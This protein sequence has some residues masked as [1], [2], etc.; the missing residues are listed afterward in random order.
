MIDFLLVASKRLKSGEVEIY[1]KFVIKNSKDLMIRGRDFY[2]IWLEEEG[3]WSTDEQQ[4]IIKMDQILDDYAHDHID[5]YNYGY[6]ILHLWDA[7]TGM[8]DNWHKYCQ[9]QLRD[10]FNP[11]D[12]NLVFANTEVSKK[13]YSSKRL[14]YSLEAGDI[15]AYDTLMDVL[16][17]PENRLKI[18]WAIGAV[19][20]GDSKKIQKFMVLYGSA[21]TGKS[22]VLNIIQMLFKGYYTS[23]DARAVGSSSNAFALEAFKSNPLLGIQHDG[24]L[25]KISDNARLNMLV[26]HEEMSVNEKYKASFNSKFKCFLFMGTNKPVQ[27]TDA[28]SGLIRRLID[29]VPTGNKVSRKDYTKLTKRV[30]F[31]LGAIAAHCLEVYSNNKAYFDDY[32]PINMLGASNDFYNF[33]LDAYFDF[34]HDDCTTLKQAWEMYKR[35]CDDA[36]VLYPLPQRGFKEELKNYFENY[37]ERYRGPDDIRIRNYYYTFKLDKF[38]G[39][40]DY[41][42]SSISLST[43]NW[44]TLKD[45]ESVFDNVAKD[46]PA[47][48]ANKM[49]TPKIAWKNNKQILKEL[50]THKLHYVH[51]PKEHIVIDFDMVGDDGEKC[52]D[53][54]L[55][56]AALFPPTYAEVSKSGNGLHLHY[57][58]S[59]DV[60]ALSQIFDNDIEIKKSIGDSSLRR[61]LTKCNGLSIAT[62]NSGLPIKEEVQ[63]MVK[64][65]SIKSEKSLRTLIS[66]NLCKEIHSYTGPSIDFIWQILEDA[67][68]S[69]LKYDVNDMHPSVLHF[70]ASS[71]HQ[72][73]RCVNKVATMK[74][75]SEE[76]EVNLT[77]K[78]LILEGY[79]EDDSDIVFYDM[80][81]FPNLYLI[82][83][84]QIGEGNQ[85]Y[86]MINPTPKEVETFVKMKLIGFNNRGYDNHM[87][88][89]RMM[90]YSELEVYKLS[91]RII[92]RKDGNND[93]KFRE[94]YNLSYSDIYDFASAQHKMSLKK[95]EIELGIHHDEL[96]GVKWDDPVPPDMI[97]RVIEYCGFDVLASEAVFNHLRGDWE[98]R[99]I[100]AKIT[101]M[102]VNSSTNSLSTK[103]IFGNEK[104]PNGK[105]GTVF[106][107]RDLSKPISCDRYEECC[108]RYERTE[109]RVFDDLGEPIHKTYVPGDKYPDGYSIMPFFPGYAF[110]L[111]KSTYR[112][113]ELGEGGEVYAE[114]GMY[115]NVGLLDVASM[116]PTSDI[117]EWYQGPYTRK[118]MEVVMSRLAIKH[119]NFEALKNLLGGVLYEL[120]LNASDEM[121]D[122]I[123]L[124]LKTVINSV[125]GLTCTHY[126]NP[127]VDARNADNIIAKR[128]ALFMINLKFKVE[129]A[130]FIVAHI[131]TDSIKIP[132]ATPEIL[133]MVTEYGLEYGYTFEHEA[134]YDRMCLVNNAV[135]IAKY[136]T[137]EKC[138]NLYGSAPKD[139]QRHGDQWTATGKQF[140]VPYIFK[141]LFS[142][143]PY[144]FEDY[145]QTFSVQSELY[146]DTNE[147]IFDLP[148]DEDGLPISDDHPSRHDYHFIGKV[149]NFCPVRPGTG[150]GLLMRKANDKYN[151]ASGS[152]GYRWQESEM[153][154]NN[155]LEEDIDLAY[156]DKMVAKAYTKIKENSI[157]IEGGADWFMSDAPYVPPLFINDHPMYPEELPFD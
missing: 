23:F 102:S 82:R 20:S 24:D 35:Y 128:G 95:W 46:F 80:E 126:D 4:A 37:A 55:K 112:G 88:Y 25:S 157:N 30:E 51:V 156:F 31:E 121:L 150:G 34:K 72:A 101:G 139:N 61:M 3:R 71:S 69:G 92:G 7:E 42:K 108:D 79:L 155:G 16:Y 135:Y 43:D 77:E 94:A 83:W 93:G 117:Q 8:I 22:T 86:T 21:G 53:L 142:K 62:I 50:D 122:A 68:N 98:A 107:W 47:Q 89:A 60:D 63:K 99:K 38:D 17:S 2:A 81:I 15:E 10:S 137:E 14:P 145:C 103:F 64:E 124:A 36:N 52:L 73:Q 54:N 136:A 48:Y 66:R 151:Y 44:L 67:Y 11:L 85:I 75:K 120:T 41:D 65:E 87:L 138:M 116:H 97:P 70:A 91:K 78:E 27:I 49:G 45:Q 114:P 149:G 84:K 12:E 59:G 134:T 104:N 29:V 76:D 109:F 143:E 40:E 129:A 26:S 152:K 123:S 153:I 119:R 39:S 105:F 148:F 113:V 9:K 130:G 144:E 140:A 5:E 28:K 133:K 106:N 154:R 58:Y 100:L 33:M 111:G 56:A 6:K 57:I 115:G 132:D 141:S 32:V 18:E 90:G 13:D 19:V 146:L 74:F 110:H 147:K 96:G 1:P 127:F 118:Y 125:Y 131:K